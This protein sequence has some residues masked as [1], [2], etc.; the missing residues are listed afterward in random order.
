MPGE[1]ELQP[2]IVGDSEQVAGLEELA[3]A[4][5]AERLLEVDI[6]P[7]LEARQSQQCALGVVV[8]ERRDDVLEVPGDL[9][10]A[11]LVP[12]GAP[13]RRPR[14]SNAVSPVS[15]RLDRA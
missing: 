8:F 10:E 15:C 3:D 5:R 6:E 7:G 12:R 13:W 4:E 2:R 1:V 9:V 14:S 11:A